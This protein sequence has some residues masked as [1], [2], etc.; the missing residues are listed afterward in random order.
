MG[1]PNISTNNV[2]YNV[3]LRT[4][5]FLNGN[6]ITG[7]SFAAGKQ[8]SKT[9]YYGSCV[10][11]YDFGNQQS[12]G[13]VLGSVEK[14]YNTGNKKV[15]MSQEL[16]GEAMKEKG[17][18]DSKI[19]YT[20]AKFNAQ[21]GKVNVSFD[22]RVAVHFDGTSFKHNIETLTIAAMPLTKNN[23]VSVYGIFQTYDT[24]NLFKSGSY[25]NISVN[26]GIS[27]SL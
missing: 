13:V 15:W 1:E 24:A 25:N 6:N 5:Q 9:S 26:A 21:L 3:L 4:F 23:K 2:N 12:C 14:K 11:G 16:Y 20:P 10:L 27:Y 19:T 22:P 8:T 18:F 17:V 7:A